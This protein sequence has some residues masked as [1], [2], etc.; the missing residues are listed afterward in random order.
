MTNPRRARQPTSFEERK[1]P[2]G[3]AR[4]QRTVKR[5]L[6]SPGDSALIIAPIL[7]VR[8]SIVGPTILMRPRVRGTTGSRP[9]PALWR[10]GWRSPAWHSRP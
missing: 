3:G 10:S 4:S 8:R 1:P 9:L 7:T 2:P 6:R 5:I